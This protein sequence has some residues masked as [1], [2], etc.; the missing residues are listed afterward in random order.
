MTRLTALKLVD[1]RWKKKQHTYVQ[2]I[3]S[4]REN[5]D[6]AALDAREAQAQMYMH[7]QMYCQVISIAWIFSFNPHLSLSF[8]HSL[9]RFYCSRARKCSYLYLIQVSLKCKLSTP[10]DRLF[11]LRALLQCAH[12]SKPK[13]NNRQTASVVCMCVC[14][15]F[16]VSKYECQ[17]NCLSIQKFLCL[18]STLPLSL[19]CFS[20]HLNSHFRW[21]SKR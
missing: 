17:M 15:H 1:P 8:S 10:I 5:L 6:A 13:S 4:Q 11:N 20:T 14:C 19:Q 7:K 2:A 9:F 16:T 21:K 18:S 12:I 3:D